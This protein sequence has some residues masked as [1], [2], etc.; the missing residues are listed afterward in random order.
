MFSKGSRWK[1]LGQSFPEV[2]YSSQMKSQ[3]IPVIQRYRQGLIAHCGQLCKEENI[4]ESL[5]RIMIREST[6]KPQQ[7]D[8]S[9]RVPRFSDP[10]RTAA[11][12]A[13]CGSLQV[14][15]RPSLNQALNVSAT[16]FISPRADPL[17]R[18]IAEEDG[19]TL[20]LRM[21]S[22]TQNMF[23]K[24]TP[25]S[26][27]SEVI[28]LTS[29]KLISTGCLFGCRPREITACIVALTTEPRMGFQEEENRL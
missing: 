20:A 11:C 1:I 4:S 2:R 9:S 8:C 23:T 17:S 27:E 13:T 5:T 22:A 21:H 7:K 18:M 29:R 16:H 14:Q 19:K 3:T 10:F 15:P 28:S 25:L 24:R 12:E 26:V 6:T